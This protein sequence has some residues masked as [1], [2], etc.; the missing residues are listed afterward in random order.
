[1]ALWH[2]ATILLLNILS[3]IFKVLPTREVLFQICD[4]SLITFLNTTLPLSSKMLVNRCKTFIEIALELLKSWIIGIIL[5]L[6]I[7]S[8]FLI[9]GE[10]LTLGPFLET[11]QL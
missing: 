4:I 7:T 10:I 3:I 8:R 1:M 6:T 5:L 2:F 9:T 11:W